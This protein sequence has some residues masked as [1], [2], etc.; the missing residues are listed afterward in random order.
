MCMCMHASVRAFKYIHCSFAC[1]DGTH[2]QPYT[3]NNVDRR[4]YIPLRT[5]ARVQEDVDEVEGDARDEIDQEPG[6]EV[7][8]FVCVCVVIMGEEN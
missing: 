8:L 4:T 2:N 3:H 5:P 6:A 1:S 7:F